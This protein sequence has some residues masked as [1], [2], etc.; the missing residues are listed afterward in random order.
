[1]AKPEEG[2][3]EKN[4]DCFSVWNVDQAAASRAIKVK[5]QAQGG[6]LVKKQALKGLQ[7]H[8]ER[9][10]WKSGS[11][12]GA[13]MC[14]LEGL[15]GISEECFDAF[16]GPLPG[17]RKHLHPMGPFIDNVYPEEIIELR[18]P[19]KS[20]PKVSIAVKKQIFPPDKDD[21]PA[22]LREE[23]VWASPFRQVLFYVKHQQISNAWA[24]PRFSKKQNMLYICILL[25]VILRPPQG[26]DRQGRHG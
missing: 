23:P 19:E 22:M 20:E 25:C 10:L 16:A 11:A 13:L 24:H 6:V 3:R 9:R 8:V 18:N 14:D 5:M 17:R 1:M 15:P 7:T 4:I 2:P 12:D 26:E 21:N